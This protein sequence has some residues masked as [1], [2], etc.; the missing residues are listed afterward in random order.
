MG[1]TDF[2][3]GWNVRDYF[4]KQRVAPVDGDAPTYAHAGCLGRVEC[5]TCGKFHGYCRELVDVTR[6]ADTLK[7]L[8]RDAG[9][10]RGKMV[11]LGSHYDDERKSGGKGGFKNR[12][13]MKAKDIPAKGGKCKVIDFRVAPKQMEYSD[14][15]LD[16]TMGKKE[17]TIGL[18]SKSV[19][20]N[21][22]IDSMGKKTDKWVGRTVTLVRGGPKGQY[23][24][25]A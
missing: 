7:E 25:V 18:R 23:I 3:Y 24:N 5:A 9:I 12:P 10:K 21:M 22:L 20:L 17:F 1:Q 13:F 4:D 6:E 15:L 8:I 16:V 14:F 2:E 19:L 11:D